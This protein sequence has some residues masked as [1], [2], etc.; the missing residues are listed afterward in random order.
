MALLKALLCQVLAVIGAGA[1]NVAF[2]PYVI[3]FGWLILIQAVFA[4]LLSRVLTQ[5]PWWQ[6]INLLFLPAVWSLLSVPIP[7]WLY[8]LGFCIL[9]LVFWGT[10]K[11]DVPLFLS[12]TEVTQTLAGIIKQQQCKNLIELGAG[13]GSVVVPLATEMPELQIT[14]LEN[15]PLPWLILRWRCRH[16]PNVQVLRRSLWDF[17]LHHFDLAFAFLSPLV[18][19]RLHE[20]AQSQMGDGSWLIS[21]SFEIPDLSASKVV[22][23]TDRRKTRLFC[24]RFCRK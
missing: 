22:Q 8:L 16:L 3:N 12:S 21:S 5:P 17:G 10:V 18:M 11:G 4:S 2:Q 13:V 9:M 1:L 7:A 14:A 6:W 15:A 23:L 24:Y 20:K 19:V